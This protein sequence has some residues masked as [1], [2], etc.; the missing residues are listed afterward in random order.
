MPTPIYF[1]EAASEQA[2]LSRMDPKPRSTR[3]STR[4]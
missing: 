4:S 1:S 2:V 3:A